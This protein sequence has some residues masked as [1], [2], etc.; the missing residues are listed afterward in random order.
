MK[1]KSKKTSLYLTNFKKVHITTINRFIL[2]QLKKHRGFESKISIEISENLKNYLIKSYYLSSTRFG[3]CHAF[4]KDF[5]LIK[6]VDLNNNNFNYIKKEDFFLKITKPKVVLYKQKSKAKSMMTNPSISI[7]FFRSNE[8]HLNKT[9]L[10]F[11]KNYN[12]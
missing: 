7:K 9:Q 11:I 12:K 2:T 3:N 5:K 8:I 1:K 6:R 10:N 4:L